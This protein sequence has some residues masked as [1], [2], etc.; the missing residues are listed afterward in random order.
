MVQE[1]AMDHVVSQAGLKK[2]DSI[3][4][5]KKYENNGSGMLKLKM[6]LGNYLVER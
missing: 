3:G 5:G 4:E 2:I 6:S 1:D